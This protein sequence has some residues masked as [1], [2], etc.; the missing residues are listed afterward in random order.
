MRPVWKAGLALGAAAAGA[1]AWVQVNPQIG[2]L[3]VYL[4]PTYGVVWVPADQA[5]NVSFSAPPAI[6]NVTP[7]E[8]H[9]AQLY[10][11]GQTPTT[12]SILKVG[13]P[14]WLTAIN[15]ATESIAATSS[16]SN[17]GQIAVIGAAKTADAG[18]NPTNAIGLLGYV[19]N[20]NTGTTEHAYGTLT[21][22]RRGVGIRATSVAIGIESDAVEHNDYTGANGITPYN[23]GPT[24]GALSASLWAASGDGFDLPAHPPA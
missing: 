2:S 9:F 10:A 14:G 22:A 3:W 19:W 8:G 24:T 18:T 12:G 15:G 4:G 6:G 20:N 5:M 21:I 23:M 7:N 1:V 17:T 13:R 16:L 11:T